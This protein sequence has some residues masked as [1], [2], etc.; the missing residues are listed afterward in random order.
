MFIPKISVTADASGAV[1]AANNGDIVVIVDVID[2]STTLETC[3]EEGAAAVFGASPN[4]KNLPVKVYPEKIVKKAVGLALKL[5]T[6]IVIIGEPRIGEDIKRYKNCEHIIELVKREGLKI[7]KIIPNLG[8]EVAKLIS[9]KN[10]IIIAVTDSG[11]IAF[12]AAYGCGVQVCTATIART[13]KS[14]G[15]IP[16]KNGAIRAIN[17]SKKYNS[18]ISVIAASSNSIEDV[19][20]AKYIADLIKKINA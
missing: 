11:G 4:K 13:I 12:D 19:L 20:A 17:L 5:N 10:K 2:M 14:K 18:D 1:N 7:E 8:K 6:S 3:L 15:I 9:L 16:A